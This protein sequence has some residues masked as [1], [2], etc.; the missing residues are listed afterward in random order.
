MYKPTIHVY[1]YI[2]IYIDY[3]HEDLRDQMW[4]NI[5]EIPDNGIDDD[6]NGIIDDVYGANFA[7]GNGD[8]IYIYIYI[9][10]ELIVVD[11]LICM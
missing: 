8:H 9:Y 1:I 2:Y 3:L 10:T 6:G 7:D 4:V 5:H 11:V